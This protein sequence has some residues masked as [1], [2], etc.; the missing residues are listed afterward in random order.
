MSITS[1]V[2]IGLAF[3]AVLFVG[4][5]VAIVVWA[6]VEAIRGRGNR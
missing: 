4:F 2:L 1:F 5:C 3:I 6:I